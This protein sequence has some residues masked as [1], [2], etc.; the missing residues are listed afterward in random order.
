MTS[1]K[2]PCPWMAR[3]AKATPL[4][5]LLILPVQAWGNPKT[6]ELTKLLLERNKRAEVAI[7]ELTA[8]NDELMKEIARL[9]EEL[10]K[11][12]ESREQAPA[13]APSS[14]V[15]KPAEEKPRP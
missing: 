13:A 4:L 15:E 1:A 11:Q 2:Q 3:L 10:K 14:P 8:K 5:V 12:M 9:K 7:T 6:S